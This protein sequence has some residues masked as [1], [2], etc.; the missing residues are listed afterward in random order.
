[1]AERGIDLTTHRGHTVTATELTEA[2][3]I[4]VMTRSHR[5][6]L[7]AE[8][9]ECRP[10]LHL[11]SELKDRTFDIDDPYGQ[12]RAEYAKTARELELLIDDGYDKILSWISDGL[13]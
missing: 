11:M 12:D 9:P 2:A 1:M 10:R 13:R 3:A 5:D 4:I 7:A 8:F 6:A